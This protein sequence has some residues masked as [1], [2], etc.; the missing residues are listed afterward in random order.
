MFGRKALVGLALR[1]VLRRLHETARTLGKF[2]EVHRF[3]FSGSPRWEA[4]P[5]CE[6]EYG[7]RTKG[8]R[9]SP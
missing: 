8:L 6:P 2:L 1:E 5:L 7:I 9:L 3:L 4:A